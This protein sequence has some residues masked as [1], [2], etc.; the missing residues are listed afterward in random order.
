MATDEK[1]CL[2]WS[3]KQ[4]AKIFLLKLSGQVDTILANT[5]TANSLQIFKRT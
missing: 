3:R 1:P 2:N 5:L 4:E